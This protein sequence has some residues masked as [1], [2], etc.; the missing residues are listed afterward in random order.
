[1]VCRNPPTTRSRWYAPTS[2][3]TVRLHLFS[4]LHCPPLNRVADSFRVGHVRDGF[5]EYPLHVIE[6]DVSK[7]TLDDSVWPDGSPAIDGVIMCYDASDPDSFLP[8]EGLLRELTSS[9][10]VFAAKSRFTQSDSGP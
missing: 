8:V 3:P 6:A 4:T 1:M 5:E 9:P 10:L 7:T 2:L